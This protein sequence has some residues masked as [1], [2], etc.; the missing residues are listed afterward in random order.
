MMRVGG[1]YP[2]PVEM[3]SLWKDRARRHPASPESPEPEDRTW[4]VIVV[5]AG[6][7]GLTTAL[8]LARAGK[9]VLVIEA[10]EAGAGTTGGSTAKVSLLQGTTLSRIARRHPAEVVEQY[11]TANREGQAWLTDYCETHDVPVQRRAAY[12]HAT[13]DKGRD[14]ARTEHNVARGAGLATEWTKDPP[15]P[16]P[17]TG[18]VRLDDQAQVDPMQV[19]S[20]LADD[21]VQHGGTLLQG[22]RVRRV[23][24]RGP[25]HVVT[26]R[27]DHLAET[28]VVATNMPIL[29]RGGFFSRATSE[30]SYGLAFRAPDHGVDA[31]YL[32]A[33]STSRSLRDAPVDGDNLLLVGGNGH[34][35]GRADSELARVR[36][37]VD[38]TTNHFP[39]AS[40]THA[41][42]AQDYVTASA[43]PF[44]GPLTPHRADL[45][46]AGGY[47]KWGM[48]NAV[49]AALAL[50]SQV[51]GGRL[52]WAQPLR[53]WSRPRAG[54]VM[55]AAR[56]NAEVGLEM[57]RGWLRP[58]LGAADRTSPAEGDGRVVVDHVGLPTAVSQVGAQV[59]R[60]SAVCPHLGGI[61]R[62]NDA[63]L[64]WD[65]PLH[66]SR[67]APDG[68]VLEGPATCP[69]GDR[70]G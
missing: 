61:L 63:E 37:L 19:I 33:D 10:L 23:T 11:V 16:F 17:T 46:V 13:T 47:A 64:S 43:L 26:D 56:I 12:T 24:G 45:L 22:C 18:A 70:S 6:L 65:C 57:T 55:D 3:K 34:P 35:T 50:S 30:R 39:G 5:G 66:G 54:Q 58:V 29:D 2:P 59:R 49:A 31:M 41:W 69:L 28:V 62:W 25:A 7:T 14:A 8:L 48:T 52:E 38:W 40:L 42:S 60:V 32:S 44:V 4:D 21:L 67:F 68:A 51:L 1:G 27:G 9:S 36:E 20:A 15:L 53:T